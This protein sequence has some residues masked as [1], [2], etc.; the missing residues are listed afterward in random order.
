MTAIYEDEENFGCQVWVHGN[1]NLVAG[2]DLVVQR[3]VAPPPH[4]PLAVRCPQCRHVT[5]RGT[6]LC[7]HCHHDIGAWLAALAA[8]R[9]RL[10]E[11]QRLRALAL[12]FALGAGLG[13]FAAWTGFF[14]GF[15]QLFVI[16]VT[17]VAAFGAVA[18]L[19]ASAKL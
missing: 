2:R 12:R 9:K 11:I 19:D 4:H 8:G 14:T 18:A 1:G 7:V 13:A 10:M 16:G 15:Q 5:W 6:Q 17:G 3:P